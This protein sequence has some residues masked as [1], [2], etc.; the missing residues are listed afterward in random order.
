[1]RQVHVVGDYTALAAYFHQHY[2]E[3]ACQDEP[4]PHA[5]FYHRR[6]VLKQHV[7]ELMD[8]DGIDPDPALTHLLLP[9]LIVGT[10]QG[11]HVSHRPGRVVWRQGRAEIFPLIVIEV[12]C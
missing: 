1:M 3:V 11:I 5:K 2:D 7:E 12:D 9:R 4:D 6:F 8:E 10:V